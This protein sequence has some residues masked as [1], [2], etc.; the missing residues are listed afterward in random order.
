MP[1]VANINNVV[2]FGLET[3]IGTSI[4]AGKLMQGMMVEIGPEVEIS[5]YRPSGGKF[6]TVA[7]LDR[8]WTSADL[9]GPITYTELVYP[10]SSV[11]KK[12]TPTGAGAA[13][14]WVLAPAQTQADTVASFT[15]ETGSA[16]RAQK[17]SYGLVTDLELTFS[18]QGNELKGSMIGKAMTDGIAMTGTPT[19]LTL[20]PVLPKDVSVKLAD[21]QGTLTAATANLRVVSVGW[22]VGN[23][24]GPVWVLN[25]STS[26]AAHV[27]LPIDLECTL[28]VQ[29]DTEGNAL[30]TTMRSGATKWMRIGCVSDSL[31]EA[32][33]PYSLQIDTACKVTGVSKFEDEDGVKVIEWT[34]GGFYDSVAGFATQVTLVN[35]STAL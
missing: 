20:L 28:R 11:L 3:T 18:T 23:R 35:V 15:V 7:A 1:E 10:L 34:M 33:I 27:E 24:F 14:T 9:S 22:K 5:T 31:A 12:V 2:Q 8:E 13:K 30:F 25:N 32:A 26:W 4:A 17:F 16:V 6:E 19:A 29:A 21:T